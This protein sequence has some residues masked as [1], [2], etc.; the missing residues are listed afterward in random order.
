MQL[1][2]W[3]TNRVDRQGESSLHAGEQMLGCQLHLLG[4]GRMWM[5][6]LMWIAWPA[7]LMAGVIEM[8]VFAFVD[9]E[10]LQWFDQP[11]HLSR[12][13]VYTIAFFTFWFVLMASSALTTLLSLSPFELNRCPVPKG[14]RPADCAKYVS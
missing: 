9:P 2:R 4:D 12:E 7:F 8:V 1:L 10:A 11:L 5:Q 3:R 13:G 6:R 14:A